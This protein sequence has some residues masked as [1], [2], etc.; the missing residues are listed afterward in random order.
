MLVSFSLRRAPLCDLLPSLSRFGDPGFNREA[1]AA[2]SSRHCRNPDVSSCR[3]QREFEEFRPGFIE[4]TD[5]G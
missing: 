3:S 1:R 4:I 2:P 5:N